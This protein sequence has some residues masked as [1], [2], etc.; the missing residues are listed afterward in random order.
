MCVLQP[1]EMVHSF[2]V[3]ALRASAMVYDAFSHRALDL[4]RPTAADGM[5][6]IAKGVYHSSQPL[7]SRILYASD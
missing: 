1:V 6:G 3:V 7:S 2:D 5:V 4:G